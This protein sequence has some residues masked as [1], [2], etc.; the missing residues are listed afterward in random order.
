MSITLSNIEHI[1]IKLKLNN[2]LNL[3]LGACYI[4]PNS[5][6]SVYTKHVETIEEILQTS[7]NVKFILTGDY[8]LP[9]VYFSN[10]SD[11]LIFNGVHSDKADVIF[12]F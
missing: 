11:G 3:I 9:N 2:T 5:L 8:N 6:L 4:P 10:D 7:P 1:F 12:R